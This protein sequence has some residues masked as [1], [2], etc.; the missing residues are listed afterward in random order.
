MRAALAAFFALAFTALGQVSYYN[1]GLLRQPD[2]ATDRAYLGITNWSGIFFATNL[3]GILPGTNVFFTTNGSGHLIINASNTVSGAGT[4]LT[5]GLVAYYKLNEGAGI[6]AHDS[7]PGALHASLLGATVPVWISGNAYNGG[8]ALKF[9]DDTSY[10][11]TPVWPSF[12]LTDPAI[13]AFSI[14]V[15][16]CHT[17]AAWATW[18]GIVCCVNNNSFLLRYDAN[19]ADHMRLFVNGPGSILLGPPAAQWV[20]NT[21]YL[22]TVSRSGNN[23]TMWQND[24]IVATGNSATGTD[25]IP[26]L[27]Q[28]AYIGKDNGAAGRV[29]RGY[30]GEVR[31]YK[32]YALTDG[33]VKYLYNT[34][35]FGQPVSSLYVQKAGD[36]MTGDLTVET[37]MRVG[38]GATPLEVEY[39]PGLD[40]TTFSQAGSPTLDMIGSVGGYVWLGGAAAVDTGGVGIGS[41]A[42]A[43]GTGVGIGFLANGNNLGVSLGASSQGYDN[44]VAV[45]NASVGTSFSVGIGDTAAASDHAVAVGNL[46]QTKPYA[47]AIGTKSD[48]SGGDASIAIGPFATAFEQY[49]VAIGTTN[50]TDFP[51]Y[52][53]TS[54]GGVGAFELGTG[55]A[56]TPWALHYR[57][58]PIVDSNGVFMAAGAI[59]ITT[60]ICVVFCDGSTNMLNITNGLI[61]AINAPIGPPPAHGPS[62]VW[63][64]GGYIIWKIGDTILLP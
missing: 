61:V 8:P 19:G 54:G 37:A 3:S 59:G 23:Y 15:W 53:G 41:V 46:T 57:G 52:A 2:A 10:V 12:N 40:R 18:E 11:G 33:D 45:G 39:D 6:I 14:S 38:T 44:G 24:V 17:N 26:A 29:W 27:Q 63:P 42:Q 58:H 55:T 21:W 16:I 25:N 49:S 31:F 9:T 43:T 30:I 22:L 56:T 64:G 62:W 4:N 60:N 7:M 47:I 1:Q 50:A 48:A 20:M 32:G 28:G 35:Y 51:G 36:T 13:P 34:Y 5:T